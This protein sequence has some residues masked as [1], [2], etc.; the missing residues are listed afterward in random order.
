MPVGIHKA[1]T[2]DHASRIDNF[3]IFDVEQGADV[4]DQLPFE[5]HV[6]DRHVWYCRIYRKD[7]TSAD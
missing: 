4:F 6:A 2:H 1:G 3:G 5:Q 7:V